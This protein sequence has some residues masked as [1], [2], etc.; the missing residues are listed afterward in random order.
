MRLGVSCVACTFAFLLA[1]SACGSEGEDDGSS[2]TDPDKDQG[3]LGGSDDPGGV[4][5]DVAQFNACATSRNDGERV[6]AY[7]MLLIDGSGSMDGRYGGDLTPKPE[8][9]EADPSP[10]ANPDNRQTGKKWIAVRDALDAFFLG[11]SQRPDNS[12][13]VGMALYPRSTD[14]KRSVEIAVVDP[15]QSIKLRAIMAPPVYADAKTTPLGEALDV[16]VPKLEAFTPAAPLRGGG[17]R[18]F[19]LMTDGLPNG[20]AADSPA[21]VEQKV[22]AAKA[23]SPTLFSF[24]VGVG[25]EGGPASSYD[26]LLMGKLATAGGTAASGCNPNWGDKDKT[27]TPCHL[28]ITPGTKSAAQIRD[29]FAAAVKRV[30]TSLSSCDFILD[31]KDGTVLNPALVN[32]VFV[33]G[34]GEQEAV[35]QNA[36]DGWTYDNPGS[37]SVVTLHGAACEKVKNDPD[38]KIRI[39]LGCATLVK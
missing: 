20:T 35:A 29:E 17:R 23:G 33:P 34:G 22:K 32:V 30:Q 18:A 28:Q 26:E 31:K 1:L 15:A 36:K 19:M 21:N 4:F 8:E 3:T 9:R 39:V 25:D 2:F 24:A 27:G 14:A 11:L 12:L 16:W 38:G 6:P 5:G 13:G 37:P 10:Q 7:L